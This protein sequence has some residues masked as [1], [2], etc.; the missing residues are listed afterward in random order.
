MGG[1]RRCAGYL[2]IS[3]DFRILIPGKNLI[4]D[5]DFFDRAVSIPGFYKSTCYEAE[6]RAGSS[7][8]ESGTS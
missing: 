8:P 4:A 5:F 3:E 6:T 2:G 7:S 1:P